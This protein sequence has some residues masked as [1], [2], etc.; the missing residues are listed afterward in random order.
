VLGVALGLPAAWV[1]SRWVKSM[2]FGLT[3]T[4]PGSIAAAALLISAASFL[5]AYFPARRAAR[6]NPM[7]ALRHD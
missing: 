7:V 5:A 2:L 1:A 3:A 6:V 4:D